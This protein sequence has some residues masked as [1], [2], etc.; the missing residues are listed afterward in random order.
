[1]PISKTY[2]MSLNIKKY[3]YY[4]YLFN[5]NNDV[6]ETVEKG[7]YVCLSVFGHISTQVPLIAKAYILSSNIFKMFI[8]K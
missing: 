5:N 2:V 1:M 6:L 8:L 4:Q 3:F 7:Y